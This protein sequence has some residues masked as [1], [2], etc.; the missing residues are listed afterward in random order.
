MHTTG[1]HS[2]LTNFEFQDTL[3]KR[4]YSL[5][6]ILVQRSLGISFQTYSL[7]KNIKSY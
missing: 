6:V 2:R 5:K 7:M 4:T 3:H 1:V